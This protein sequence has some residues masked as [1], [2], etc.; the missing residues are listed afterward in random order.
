[1]NGK[2]S[3][4]SGYDDAWDSG[5]NGVGGHAPVAVITTLG[6]PHCKRVRTPVFDGRPEVTAAWM[7]LLLSGFAR[8]GLL[9]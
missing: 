8:C 6:C 4:L 5:S 2:H 3:F 9:H 1:M 7:A